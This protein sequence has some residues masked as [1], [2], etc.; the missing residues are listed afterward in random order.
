MEDTSAI[1]SKDNINIKSNENENENKEDSFLEEKKINVKGDDLTTLTIWMYSIGH[2]FNDLVSACW[3]FYFSY[4]MVYIIE[5]GEDRSGYIMLA[6]QIFDGIGTLL[7]G[8]LSDQ[9]KSRFGKRTPWFFFGTIAVTIT[10]LIIYQGCLI[11]D[12]STSPTVEF[13]YLIISPCIFNVGW[14][15][16][17]VSHMALLPSL[18]LSK[19]KQEKMTRLRTG[20]TFA[21]Q[22]LA[23]ALS[24]LIFYLFPQKLLQYRILAFS[25]AALGLVCSVLFLIFVKEV[26][27]TKNIKTYYKAIKR[28][29]RI[30][31][32]A[33]IDGYVSSDMSDSE[34]LSAIIAREK[35]DKDDDEEEEIINWK[36]WMSRVDFYIYMLVYMF[37]RLAINISSSFIS[38]YC[39]NVLGWR[40]EDHSTPVQISIILIIVTIGSVINSMVF[41][42]YIL[43]RLKNEYKRLGLM[44]IALITMLIGCVPLYFIQDTP[45]IFYILAFFIGIGYSAG[46]SGASSL[47]N[48]VVGN[49]ASKGAFVYGFYSLSDK[50]SCGI[51][52]VYMIR[53]AANNFTQLTIFMAFF[54]PLSIFLALICILIKRSSDKRNQIKESKKDQS[55][56][57]KNYLD[58]PRLSFM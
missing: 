17:Q 45:Y 1:P 10:Y 4:Y 11:C 57:K 56:K 55:S 18:T 9:T 25:C 16:V 28:I 21:S 7:S 46:L 40:N 32:G 23:L 15:S 36:Y 27:L 58:D 41:E 38:F 51:C 47:I 19:Q 12:E 43:A 22:L 49:K 50:I 5:V 8:I 13:I 34:A 48:D 20:F 35:E 53:I 3:F 31:D 29:I 6:G 44:V 14:A 24:L 26:E 39:Q 52:I 30:E 33:P 2:V 54:P 42:S 37:V